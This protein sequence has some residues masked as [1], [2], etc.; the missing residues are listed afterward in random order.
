MA[1]TN[2]TAMDGA[3]TIMAAAAEARR[4]R[5]RS[6]RPRR[7]SKSRRRRP[8]RRRTR[9]EVEEDGSNRDGEVAVEAKAEVAMEGTEDTEDSKSNHS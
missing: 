6:E 9:R 4:P 2:P 7:R 5:R 1:N 8:R 3:H